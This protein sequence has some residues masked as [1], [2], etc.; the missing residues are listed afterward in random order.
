MIGTTEWAMH[1]TNMRS[2]TEAMDSDDSVGAGVCIQSALL[3][4]GIR[5]PLHNHAQESLRG[6]AEQKH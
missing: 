6:E 1:R 4:L 5:G 2:P 3:P